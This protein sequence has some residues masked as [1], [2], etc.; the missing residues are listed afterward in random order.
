MVSP[1]AAVQLV[2]GTQ[3]SSSAT[4]GQVF[5]TQPVVY[6]VD[7]YGNIETA[8]ST[9]VV[10]AALGSGVGPLGGTTTAILQNGVAT[11]VGLNDP[12]AETIA[13]EFTAGSLVSPASTPIVIGPGAATHL[14]IQTQPYSVV[15]AGTPL[16][17]PV[18]VAEVDQYGNVVT[19]DSG[20]PVTAALASGSGTLLGTTQVTLQGGVASFNDLQVN[21]AGSLTLQFVASTLPPAVASPSVVTPAKATHLSVKRPPGGVITGSNYLVEVDALDPYGNVDTTFDGSVTL[22]PSGDGVNGNLTATAVDGVAMFTGLVTPTSGEVSF[23]AMTSG[24]ASGTSSSIAVSPA[25]PAKLVI[26]VQPPQAAAAGQPFATTGRPVVVYE[27]DQYGDIETADNSTAVT[28]FLA[29]GPGTLR[30]TL[31]ATVSGGVA[32]F[33]DLDEVTVGTIALEFTGGGL[34]SLAT[35]PITISPAAAAKLV[36]HTQPPAAATAGQP[37]ATQPVVYEEDA[38]GNLETGDSSTV[39]AVAPAGGDGPLQALT[40]ATLAGGVATFAG[41]AEDTAGALTLHFTAGGL[42]PAISNVVVVSAA[43]ATHLV[44]TTPPPSPLVPGQPFTMVVSAADAFGN[45][46]VSFDSDVTVSLPGGSGQ[47]VTAQARNGVA[48]FAGLTVSAAAQGGS[49]QATAAGVTPALTPPITLGSGAS[50][51]PQPPTIIGEQVVTSPTKHKKG[52]PVVHG[53]ML[54]F[55]AAMNPATAGSSANYQVAAAS[56][57]HGQKKSAPKF[58]PVAIRA[59]YNAANHSVTLTLLGKQTFADGGEIT[60]I[61]APPDGVSSADNVPLSSADASFNIA[62]KAAGITPG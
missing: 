8:D 55:S 13:L 50:P 30:G 20:T 61:Y 47:T 29:S 3:P 56:A 53:F 52:K 32:T 21:T 26:Q 15:T 54:D 48:T 39:V 31:T 2:I 1:A 7:Q 11:F 28:A 38:Y 45:V 24:L 18:V 6:E 44:V 33:T 49:I 5:P 42:T 34:N 51:P 14:M 10:T 46:N 58:K 43:P 37:F 60:V 62:R 17:D 9:S 12:T 57:R 35:V 23:T 25:L 16:T 22:S 4:A 41:L 59:S 27:E 40:T 19:G 36:V